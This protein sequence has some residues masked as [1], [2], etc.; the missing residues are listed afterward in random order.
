MADSFQERFASKAEIVYMVLYE[1]IR[2]GVLRPGDRLIEHQLANELGVS[3]TPVREALRKLNEQGLVTLESYKG[4]YV[5]QFSVD[6]LV[7]IMEIR[8]VLEGLAARKAAETITVEELE[9]LDA[10]VK[11]FEEVGKKGT[12]QEWIAINSQF[13]LIIATV[14][15]NEALKELLSE[16]QRKIVLSSTLGIGDDYYK[17]V[18]EHKDIVDALRAHDPEEAEHFARQHVWNTAKRVAA[19]RIGDVRAN[20]VPRQ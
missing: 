16:L 2:E 18:K 12:P 5:T 15:R 4:A 17:S 3:K 19:L 7:K 13:H 11:R 6:D 20:D 8:A 14:C 10:L 1:R 9:K